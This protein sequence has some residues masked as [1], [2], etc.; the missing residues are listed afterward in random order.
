MKNRGFYITLLV[1]F[2]LICIYNLYYTYVRIAI[3]NDLAKMTPDSSLN[4]MKQAENFERYK[5]AVDNSMSLGLDLQ[6][7]MFITME[8]GIEDILTGLC[9][10]PQDS[11]FQRALNQAKKE[12]ITSKESF[13]DL[14][15]AAMKRIDPKIRLA[16]Y[17]FGQATGLTLQAS[18]DEVIRK[19]KAE[20]EQAI[21]RCFQIIRTRID[22][23][24][25]VS[26]NI[27]KQEGT[28]RILIELPGVRDADRVRKLLRN[29]ARL[30]F[31]PTYTVQEALP[32]LEKINTKIRELEGLVTADSADTLK[33]STAQNLAADS[34]K[35][36]TNGKKLAVDT[37]KKDTGAT[38]A[39]KNDSDA[40]AKADSNLSDEEKRQKFQKEN[41][42]FALFQFPQQLPPNSPLCGY[43]RIQD[44]AKI[45]RY[46]RLPEVQNILPE[47]LKFYWTA[48]PEVE[49]SQLLALIAIKGNRDN[50]P[51]LSGD[52]IVDTK[53]DF[54]QNGKNPI[55]NMTMNTE[56]AKIWKRLTTDYLNKSIAIVLDGLVY[57][58]PTV[59]SVISNGNS[60][61]TGRFTIEE[62]KDLA[63]LLKAGKL[64]VAAKIEGEEIVGATLGADTVNK[65]LVSFILGL[66]AVLLFVLYFYKSSGIVAGI[67]LLINLFFVLGISS[68]MNVVLT[69]PGMAGIVLSIAMS[70]DANVLI[71]E[72]IREELE[73]GRSLR[74]AIGEGFQNAL[75]AIIDGNITIF[76]TGVIL[77]SFG[78]GPI[79]G[80][81]VTLIIGIITTLVTA[82][83]VTRLILDYLAGRPI[84]KK[85]SFGSLKRAEFFKKINYPFIPNRKTA[86]FISAALVIGCV[87]LFAS[88]KPKLGVDFA[89]G[90][91]YIIQFKDKSLTDADVETVRK[92][93]TA[94]FE[95]NAPQIKTIGNKANEL[96]ITTNYLLDLPDSDEQV[97]Q[98][99]KAGLEK[100]FA[101]SRPEIIK[102]TLIGPTVAR[103]IQESAIYSVIFSLLVVFSYIFIR[104]QRWQF[105]VGALASLAF[106]VILTMGVYWLLGMLN[107]SFPIELDQTFIAAIL[108]IVGYTINDAVV[109]FDRIRENLRDNRK[110]ASYAEVFNRAI[111]DTLSR[112]IVTSSTTII[113]AVILFFFG[114]DVLKGFMIALFTG[115]VVGTFSSIFIASPISLDLTPEEDT[116]TQN[117]L[118]NTRLQTATR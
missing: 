105:G 87:I 66:I 62:A 41:P 106:N 15:A 101:S 67:A 32:S 23:F 96:M 108:T 113:S 5:A 116:K 47:D 52:V 12:R 74:A 94:Q 65:G 55:V 16:T 24:G 93:L 57:T 19:L 83:L 31:W 48:K 10:D 102:S 78:S 118:S 63:N 68:A 111:N 56:G 34:A 36:D 112:T 76:L 37:T 33:D 49:E 69:L 51:P 46:M 103:D 77:Y 40:K 89:G 43:A 60:Q 26:P 115:I 54:D 98:Q 70:V 13:V 4:W 79:R 20:S 59:N 71:Y 58:Y 117:N 53:Q 86:Y 18:D 95:G 11:L 82:V 104:F 17:F 9:A 73:A 107:L 45:N 21:D 1:I 91:Q 84:G 85:L 3:D 109:V 14:F 6:G 38:I 72:R 100:S 92:D 39:S 44:T 7:G 28:G 99:T 50:Q 64:P 90:R 42:F 25:V 27:Q 110:K 114:G 22:Q 97:K 88:I 35:K 8:V 2:S 61:I 29:T 75:S 80:F 81:A 30:E